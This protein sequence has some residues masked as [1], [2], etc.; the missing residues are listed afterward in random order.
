MYSLCVPKLYVLHLTLLFIITPQTE[1]SDLSQAIDDFEFVDQAV[2]KNQPSG[3]KE[4]SIAQTLK[5]TTMSD[6]VKKQ[7]TRT[8]TVMSENDSESEDEDNNDKI[9]D[10]SLDYSQDGE[11]Q[12]SPQK[13]TSWRKKTRLQLATNSTRPRTRSRY[14]RCWNWSIIRIIRLAL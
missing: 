2:E 6:I 13:S 4:S 10:Q 12:L 1:V 8:D 9:Q 5:N 3:T 11:P 7:L 14:R